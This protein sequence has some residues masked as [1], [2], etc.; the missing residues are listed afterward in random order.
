MPDLRK[1]WEGWGRKNV[2][3]GKIERRSGII[4]LGLQ[5]THSGAKKWEEREPLAAQALRKIAEAYAQPPSQF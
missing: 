5:S 4:C 2:Q 1:D 3:R